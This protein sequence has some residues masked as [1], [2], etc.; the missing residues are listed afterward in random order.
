M[1]LLLTSS[2]ITNKSIKIALLK[3]L[4]KPF[5]KSSLT[6]IPTAANVET[7]DKSWLVEDMYNFK[8][9]GFASFDVIDISA[10]PKSLWLPSFK[11]A[12]ILVFGGGNV[13]YLLEWIRKSGLIKL[14]PKLLKNKVYVGIS[15]GSM[16][17]AKTVSLSSAGI[18]YYEKKGKP[19]NIEGLSLVNFEIRPHLNSKWFPKVRL[20]YLEKL[21]K[22]RPV[23]FY[24]I[25]DDTA[26]KVDGDKIEII[27]EGS[28]KRFN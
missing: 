18:L 13:K 8:K 3:L 4:K 16:A 6:F 11:N 27:S 10:V 14:L 15:A 12:D 20:D 21:T 28:W 9:L 19:E 5:K 17:A 23:Q 25:D 2:G 22:N 26:V 24:A 1:K 7:G